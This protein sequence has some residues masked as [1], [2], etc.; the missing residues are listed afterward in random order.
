MTSL[1]DWGSKDGSILL[2]QWE[3]MPERQKWSYFYI[4]STYTLSL[5]KY[6]GCCLVWQ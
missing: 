1:K 2:A 4:C 5:K 3:N 6:V